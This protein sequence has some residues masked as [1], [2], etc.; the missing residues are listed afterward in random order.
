ME[1]NLSSLLKDIIKDLPDGPIH[2]SF[3][4]MDIDSTKNLLQADDSIVDIL[5]YDD[6]GTN[7]VVNAMKLRQVKN[8]RDLLAD[9]N[10]QIESLDRSAFTFDNVINFVTL[11]G[12]FTR[13]IA[14]VVPNSVATATQVQV[15]LDKTPS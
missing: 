5:S 7:T 15:D 6:N 2:K 8:L 1:A 14:P 10:N 12:S 4:K 13:P 3:S 11:G 9:C